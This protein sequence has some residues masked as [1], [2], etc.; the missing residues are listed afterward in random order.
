[1]IYYLKSKQDEIWLL[2]LYAKNE[3]ETIGAATLKKIREEID[4]SR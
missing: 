3:V 2:T 1:M 4:G